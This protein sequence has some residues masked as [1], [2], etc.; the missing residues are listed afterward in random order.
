[1]LG[2]SGISEDSG[3]HTRRSTVCSGVVHLVVA[4]VVVVV[5]FVSLFDRSAFTEFVK[6]HLF[7]LV[8]IFDTLGVTLFGKARVQAVLVVVLVVVVVIVVVVVSVIVVLVLVTVLA[9]VLADFLVGLAFVLLS[10][11]QS[12]LVS[13]D[14]VSHL[15]NILST[16]AARSTAIAWA[17]LELGNHVASESFISLEHRDGGATIELEGGTA[18][19]RVGVVVVAVF[20]LTGFSQNLLSQFG[21]GLNG[22]I[23]SG[24]WRSQG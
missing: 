24:N 5:V 14:E 1:V 12:F 8:L 9:V 22:S 18:N 16:V 3:V 23:E 21:V 6:V 2:A 19:P 13:F 15:N 11:L 17:N 7:L 20:E 4:A 10:F